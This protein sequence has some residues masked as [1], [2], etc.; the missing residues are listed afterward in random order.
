MRKELIHML[1]KE[2]WRNPRAAYELDKYVEQIYRQK[3]TE[4]QLAHQY[5]QQ[6][7]LLCC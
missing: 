4:Q 2:A 7:M 1:A 3:D 5:L 6:A